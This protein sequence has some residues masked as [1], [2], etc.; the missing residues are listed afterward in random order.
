MAAV[1]AVLFDMDGLI[2]DTEWVY[3]Q[4]WQQAAQA[5]GF[6]ISEALYKTFIGVQN[7]ECERI[8]LREFGDHFPVESFREQR[9]ARFEVI[10]DQQ[11]IAEKAGFTQ[12]MRD[13]ADSAIRTALVTSSSHG[14][15]TT[16]FRQRPELDQFE[17]LVTAESVT[18]GKP[19]PDCYLLACERLSLAPQ[20]CLVLEDSNNGMRSALSAGCQ[21]IMVPDLLGPEA[22]VEDGALAIVESLVE[23]MAYCRLGV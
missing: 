11:G 18:R 17:T 1:H 23:V 4:S 5:L 20:H 3:K 2:F 16:N 21:A 22:D 10:R 7:P 13:L 12:L 19:H 15:V 8:L 14:E 6:P 9:E